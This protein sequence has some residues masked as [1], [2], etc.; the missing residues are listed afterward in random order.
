[1]IR[2]LLTESLLLA[3]LG[4]ALGMVV[5]ELGI[6][7]LV[8]LSPPGLPRA[9][10]IGIDGAVF[11]FGL[12]ITTL[13]GLVVGL[14]PALHMSRDDLHIGLQQ[15]SQSTT[16]GHQTTRRMLVVAEVALALV[17]LVSAGLL[18]RSLQR[19]FAVDPG[20]DAS[21]L[22]TMQVQT[23]GSRFD[24]DTTNRFFAQALEAVRH[25]PGV[26]AAAF[27]SQ[28][29][30]SGDL[31]EYGAHFENDSPE[32]GY[33]V[34]RYAVTPG[35]FE[36][37]GIPLRHGRLL[38]SHDVAGAPVAVLISESFAKRKF[39][40]QDPI[41]R[42]LR[43]GPSDGPWDTIVGVVG[44]VKQA[45]LVASQSDA[46][47]ITPEQWRFADKAM[48]LV[49]RARGDAAALA[50]AIK[51]AIWSV[52][53]DQP[54]ARVA[55]MDDLLAASAAERRF[56]LILFETFGLVALV[57][58]ATGIYGVLSGSVN[59]RMREIG[60]RLALGAQRRDVLHLILLQGVKLT[61]SGVVIGLLAAWAVTR[62]LTRLLYSLSATDPLTFG[63]IALFLTV[64]A[65]LACYLPARRATKVDPLVALR[66]E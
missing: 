58:A 22:L 20:L 50:P 51:Q 14:I 6:G 28:L 59:E 29:P 60:V 66:H 31:D 15:S 10:A 8:T 65:L 17:L 1:M 13:I 40:G 26:T 18:L 44:D 2:Q 24:K 25:V 41:G 54:I 27:T 48:S 30:L 36:T 7:A 62:L 61:I 35:Y 12:G 4:G 55:T 19:L 57:L 5:A 3:L 23:S 63:C 56:A 21:H 52:D 38:D 16:G 49:V 37:T 9:S 11:A 33:S 53:K 46:V 45:S 42:R 47:Y 43:V 64:V 32:A 39:P 34:F